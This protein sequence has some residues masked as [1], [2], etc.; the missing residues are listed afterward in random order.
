MASGSITLFPK[1]DFRSGW[2]KDAANM[3]PNDKQKMIQKDA[4]FIMK[5][6]FQLL[7]YN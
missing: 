2:M 1:Y 6:S 4:F 5:F 7:C 3:H